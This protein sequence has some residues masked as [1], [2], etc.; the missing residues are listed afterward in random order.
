MWLNGERQVSETADVVII[1]LGVNG[2]AAAFHLARRGAGRIIALEQG[3]MAA[4]ATGKSGALVRCHYANR[5]ETEL[6]FHS[7]H[8]FHNW[9]ELVGG[10]CGFT[11]T[12]A[13][14]L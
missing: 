13:L 12:G 4:G 5:P 3:P 6:A 11:A 1:G 14:I 8:W 10:D 9:A 7:L 2:A